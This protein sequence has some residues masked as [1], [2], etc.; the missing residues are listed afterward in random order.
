[1]ILSYMSCRK[2]RLRLWSVH[3][4]LRLSLWVTKFQKIYFNMIIYP[5]LKESTGLNFLITW[6]WIVWD[7][8]GNH[9]ENSGINYLR[10]NFDMIYFLKYLYF[11]HKFSCHN[12]LMVSNI[13]L[14]L[15]VSVFL[16]SIFFKWYYPTT[17]S[18][19]FPPF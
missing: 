6:H 7:A 3:C 9:N 17:A 2:S 18:Y 5:C 16:T 19:L 8:R 14:H 11:Q 15:L 4:N 12:F 13:V 10:N 1:M